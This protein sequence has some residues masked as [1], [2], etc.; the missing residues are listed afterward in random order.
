MYLSLFFSDATDMDYVES[1]VFAQSL[2]IAL[3]VL[4]KYIEDRVG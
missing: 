1:E 4:E 3:E 2:G